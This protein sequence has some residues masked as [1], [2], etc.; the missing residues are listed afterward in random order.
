M[1][2][3]HIAVP[4]FNIGAHTMVLGTTGKGRSKIIDDEADRLGISV[5]E[6]ER[7]LAPSPEALERQ[8]ILQ[9]EQQRR[10]QRRLSAM[11][12]AYWENSEAGDFDRLHDAIVSQIDVELGIG[13]IR[14]VF[15]RLPEDIFGLAV[16]HGFD[17]TEVGD[18]VYRFIRDNLAVIRADLG[19]GEDGQ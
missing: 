7:R 16:Q 18:H 12:Q 14:A 3:K 10:A 15:D 13:Q 9:E 2:D 11:K 4:A 5:E 8:R 17:D 6:L 1:A 19:V